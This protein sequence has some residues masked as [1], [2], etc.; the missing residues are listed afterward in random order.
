MPDSRTQSSHIAH[1]HRIMHISRHERRSQQDRNTKRAKSKS[2]PRSVAGSPVTPRSLGPGPP[3][4]LLVSNTSIP[5][6]SPRRECELI[7]TFV[8]CRCRMYHDARPTPPPPGGVRIGMGRLPPTSHPPS[9]PP[10]TETARSRARA[11]G[12]ASD[13]QSH[14]HAR[15]RG[16]SHTNLFA[17]QNR[18]V[19]RLRELAMAL[20]S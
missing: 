7:A 6:P 3:T 5:R 14:T 8:A 15:A 18:L 10:S 11:R 4:C 13:T 1:V 20:P 16:E 12:V 17:V 19:A 2:A 9:H